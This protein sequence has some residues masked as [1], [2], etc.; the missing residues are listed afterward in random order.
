M[1]EV[2]DFHAPVFT[3]VR[4]AL[5]CQRDRDFLGDAQDVEQTFLPEAIY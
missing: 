5:G 4:N 1:S 3:A 2:A